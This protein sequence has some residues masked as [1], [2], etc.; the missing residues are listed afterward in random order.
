MVNT[1]RPQKENVFMNLLCNVNF[2]SLYA[3]S[4]ERSRT[5]CKY[6]AGMYAENVAL[7]FIRKLIIK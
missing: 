3:Y 1:G 4:A 5:S 2:T 7:F 6:S